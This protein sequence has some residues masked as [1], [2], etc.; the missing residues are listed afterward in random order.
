MLTELLKTK[1]LSKLWKHQKGLM[2][3]SEQGYVK[4]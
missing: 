3:L 4:K 2:S 1:T